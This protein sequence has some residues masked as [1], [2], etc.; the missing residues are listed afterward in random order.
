MK[1]NFGYMK[2]TIIY[3]TCI[4]FI[5]LPYQLKVSILY[6][7]D[8]IKI[9]IKN[10]LYTYYKIQKFLIVIAIVKGKNFDIVKNTIY[11]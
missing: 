10:K 4:F 1:R 8:S 3:N 6:I 11:Q 9:F 5:T 2:N 7:L